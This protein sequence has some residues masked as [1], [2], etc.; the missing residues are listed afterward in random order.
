MTGSVV[1]VSFHD[2]MHPRIAESPA[3]ANGFANQVCWTIAMDAQDLAGL[4]D[5]KDRFRR[6][7][8]PCLG[9][10]ECVTITVCSLMPW[11]FCILTGWCDTLDSCDERD[12]QLEGSMPEVPIVILTVV[13]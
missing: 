11:A 13:A 9:C 5:R 8:P 7:E 1:A 4:A 6:L 2:T 3:D 10:A 12:M